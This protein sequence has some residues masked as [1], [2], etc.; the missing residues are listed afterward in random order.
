[1][2]TRLTSPSRNQPAASVTRRVH[3]YGRLAC[4]FVLA[5]LLHVGIVRLPVNLLLPPPLQSATIEL[6]LEDSSPP[7][8]TPG[9]TAADAI[10]QLRTFHDSVVDRAAVLEQ[11]LAAALE[12]QAAVEAAQ[13]QQLATLAAERAAL[14]GQVTNLQQQMTALTA[15]QAEL[16]AQLAAERERAAALERQLQEQTRAQEA[17]LA[18]V[19][20]AYDR[21]VATLKGEIA[22]KEIALHQ[23]K[24][25]LIVT[26][27]DRVLFPSGQATLTPEGRQI[28][29]KV[30]AILAKITDR[31]ILI[32]GHTDNVP[33]GPTLSQ[34]Y[35]TNWELSTARATEVVKYLITEAHLPAHRLSA[36]GRAD[37]AP[38]ASN[39]SEEGRKQNRRIEII[40]LPPDDLLHGN[41]ANS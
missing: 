20:G 36:V 21:L 28:M 40:L 27:L 11:T 7:V 34:Q 31:R 18:G 25:K 8:D 41:V 14:H 6:T 30:G 33:I 35:P 37:T 23:V 29:Q 3:P 10:Q 24:E 1:M 15:E 5:T 32:E 26:I 13:Q 12:R 39:E 16:A 17:E 2:T 19:K 4:S 38:V 22:Q 9:A